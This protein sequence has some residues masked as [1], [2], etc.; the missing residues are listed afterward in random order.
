MSYMP[1]V[2]HVEFSRQAKAPQP[3]WRALFRQRTTSAAKT[4]TALGSSAPPRPKALLRSGA[5]ARPAAAK[6]RHRWVLGL[7]GGIM[8]KW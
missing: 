2:S 3:T 8:E 6:R 1:S 5:A 4:G 7:E